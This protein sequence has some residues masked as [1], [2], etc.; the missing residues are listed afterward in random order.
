MVKRITYHATRIH[1]QV[2]ISYDDHG[3]RRPVEHSLPSQPV[4]D[5]QQRT[6]YRNMSR[7]D[8]HKAI[9]GKKDMFAHPTQPLVQSRQQLFHLR[10]DVECKVFLVS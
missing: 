8:R 9:V 6:Y 1:D 2:Y 5:P 4:G 7:K 3:V 10:T